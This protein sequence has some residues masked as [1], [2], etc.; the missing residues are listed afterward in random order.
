MQNPKSMRLPKTPT[1]TRLLSLNPVFSLVDVMKLGLTNG[2]EHVFLSRAVDAGYIVSAGY[3]SGIYY[4]LVRDPRAPGN[5]KLEAA[6]MLY[7]SMVVVGLAVIK[8]ACWTDQIAV[9]PQVAILSRRTIKC[10]EGVTFVERGLDW[11]RKM[12]GSIVDAKLSSFGVPALTPQAALEDGEMHRE[13]MGFDQWD[14]QID[15]E[16][17]AESL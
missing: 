8:D 12:K 1:V 2:Q 16:F 5:R 7:P 11:Y 17:T 15:H 10:I 13:Q 9:V 14:V 6:R 4:N 3:R